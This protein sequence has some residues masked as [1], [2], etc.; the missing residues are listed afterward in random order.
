MERS[1]SWE[2]NRFS[3][4]QEIPRILWNSKVHYRIHKCPPPVPI[5]S[6]LDPVHI[7]HI[8]PQDPSEYYPPI[9]ALPQA[10]YPW[11]ISPAGQS[12]RF[13]FYPKRPTRLWSPQSLL[14]N[15]YQKLITLRQRGRNVKLPTPLHVLLTLRMSAAMPPLPYMPS[16]P[17][18]VEF[19]LKIPTKCVS[20]L[21]VSVPTDPWGPCAADSVG[22]L[23]KSLV[24]LSLYGNV[25]KRII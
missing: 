1:P 4:N 13:L 3:A 15:A 9:Y 18:Q 17:G 8:P 6:Q 21:C 10:R 7:P 2:D 25:K 22:A 23:H 16:R 12:K 11:V 24:W 19:S 14:F 5:L 20:I